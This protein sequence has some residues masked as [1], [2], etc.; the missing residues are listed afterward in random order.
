MDGLRE[1]GY[2]EGRDFDSTC[3]DHWR[4]AKSSGAVARDEFHL[5]AIVQDLK[6]LAIRICR[7]PPHMSAAP[8]A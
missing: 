7:P 6:T 3:G 5:A 2:V 1:L 4:L 8:V